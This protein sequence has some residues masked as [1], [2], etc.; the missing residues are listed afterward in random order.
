MFVMNQLSCA[1]FYL[2]FRRNESFLAPIQR[3]KAPTHTYSIIIHF[4]FTK[5][6]SGDTFNLGG[7]ENVDRK[8]T[9]FS[10]H[11]LTTENNV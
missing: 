11:L 10:A 1:L 5:A 8:Q 6:F 7:V 3:I 4:V 9:L 2:V